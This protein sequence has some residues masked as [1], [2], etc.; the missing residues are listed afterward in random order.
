MI[1]LYRAKKGTDKDCVRLFTIARK[2]QGR[3]AI[4]EIPW[5]ALDFLN[6]IVNCS[7]A[8]LHKYSSSHVSLR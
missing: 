7:V 5:I 4:P 6:G 1:L 3:K 8:Q 2:A